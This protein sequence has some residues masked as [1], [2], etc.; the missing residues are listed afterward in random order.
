MADWNQPWAIR[1]GR[2]IF[3]RH[4]PGLLSRRRLWAV[5]KDA[6]DHGTISPPRTEMIGPAREQWR[7]DVRNLVNG[8][9]WAT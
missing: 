2:P 7:Y 1:E 9:G 6:V 3:N 8:K 4:A 5:L